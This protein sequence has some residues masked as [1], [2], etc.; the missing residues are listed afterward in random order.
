MPLLPDE[1]NYAKVKDNREYPLLAFYY[2]VTIGDDTDASVVKASFTEVS[3]LTAEIEPIE[4]RDGFDKVTVPRKV[5]GRTKYGNVT[6]KRGVFHKHLEF[7]DWVDSQQYNSIDLKVVTISLRNEEGEALIQWT[8]SNA[9]PVKIEGP[10][11]KSDGNEVAVETI[12]LVHEGL[13]VKH[14]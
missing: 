12:E 3:G 2:A 13:E 7:Q 11:L 14:V 5:P 8:L 4:Y 6:L 10:S 1:L 9:Y